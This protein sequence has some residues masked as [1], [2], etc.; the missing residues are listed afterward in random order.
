MFTRRSDLW[1]IKLPTVE[2]D[3]FRKY[4]TNEHN[5]FLLYDYEPS[6]WPLTEVKCSYSIFSHAGH[7][8]EWLTV[9][10]IMMHQHTKFGYRSFSRSERYLAKFRHMD[11]A[12]PQ[13]HW[14]WGTYFSAMCVCVWAGA[15]ALFIGIMCVQSSLCVRVCARACVSDLVCLCFCHALYEN[16]C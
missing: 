11:T 3:Q 15:H 4:G 16:V 9:L 5:L 10:L 8:L 6:L 7:G 14:G 13:F 2:K 1:A 12:I